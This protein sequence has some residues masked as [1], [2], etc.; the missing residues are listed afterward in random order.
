VTSRDQRYVFLATALATRREKSVAIAIAIAT[1]VM[2]AA[3]VPF[4][5][6][7][8]TPYPAFIPSYET[9]LFF[10]DMVTAVLLFDQ[11][12]RLRSI[13]ILLL[14]SG[15]LFDAFMTVP[16]A[17]SFPGAFT[18]TGLLGAKAQ[19]TAWL[20]VFWHGGFPI[21]VICYALLRQKEE[22]GLSWNLPPTS[23]LIGTAGVGVALLA[24]TLT[25]VTTWGHDWLP[26]MIHANDYSLSVKKG[27]G[28]SVWGITFVAMLT[29]WP[30]RQRVMDLWLLV[31]MWVWLFDI[32]LAAVLG[33]ARFDLGFYAGRLFGLIAAGFLLAT[34][35]VEMARLH[36][37]AINAGATAEQTIGQLAHSR[38][39]T[40]AG[41]TFAPA[42]VAQLNIRHFRDMLASERDQ[43]KRQTLLR[44][45]A[46]E[47]AK[48]A[49]SDEPNTKKLA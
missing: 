45:L 24:L 12:V 3:I 47:E 8:L 28:P 6:D 30:N 16:H 33:S 14:A 43:E 10:L 29:V 1:L 32:A 15:Y 25:L 18:P 38:N 4:V 7:H 31:V 37:M 35:L 34:L 48:L 2:F 13:S 9:A 49:T 46:E 27:I 21:F 39:R 41:Q 11:C 17:L 36:A 23:W 19:T 26:I 22:R 20:Y 44:L 42:S 5:R 40:D